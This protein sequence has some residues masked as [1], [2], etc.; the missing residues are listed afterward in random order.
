MCRDHR[1]L[2]TDVNKLTTGCA[3]VECFEL[4]EGVDCPRRAM[5]DPGGRNDAATR[6][7]ADD[8]LPTQQVGSRVVAVQILYCVTHD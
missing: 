6:A 5:E 2:L 7:G 8:P 1:Q 4:S 3:D